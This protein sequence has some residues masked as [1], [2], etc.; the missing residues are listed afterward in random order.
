MARVPTGK[1]RGRS[2]G[3]AK[4]GGR[5][6]GSLDRQARTLVTSE[7]A[8]DILEVYRRL[9][10]VDFLESWSR[11]NA[12]AFINSCLSRLMPPAPKDDPDIQI[13]QQYNVGL[14]EFEAARRVAFALSNAVHNGP[15]LTVTHETVEVT[16]QAAAPPEPYVNPNAWT[17]PT[18]APDMPEPVDADRARWASELPLTEEQRRD[19][20]VVRQTHGVS[21]ET[22]HGSSAEQGYGPSRPAPPRKLSPGELCRKLSRRGRD[23][24]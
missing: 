22:Y 2:K 4:T 8:G 9:G 23:L 1:P 10:G 21:L 20:A 3:C 12:T 13:N 15:G 17:P 24:L 5:T 19:N 7:V 11:T 14:S 6:V 16:P 18:D